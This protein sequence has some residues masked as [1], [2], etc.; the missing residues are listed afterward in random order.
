MTSKLMRPV[1]LVVHMQ[2]VV[3][4]QYQRVASSKCS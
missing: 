2:N 1:C 3:D 4:A